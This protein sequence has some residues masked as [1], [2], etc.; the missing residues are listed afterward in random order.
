[1][2]VNKAAADTG[3]PGLL[4]GFRALDLTDAKGYVCGK[5]LANFGVE[6]I[7]VERP[8]GDPGRY[9]YPFIGGEADP[10]KGVYWNS[11]NSDKK[12]ITLD[13]ETEQGRE[14]FKDLVKQVDFVIESFD[15]GY[16][17]GLGLGYAEL[18]KLNPRIVVTSITP[19]GQHTSR[20]NYRGGEMIC[21]A[22]CAIMDNIGD[23]DRAPL[24]E[25]S[26]TCTFF[27]NVA[28][29][30]GTMT[31]HYA[32]QRCGEGQQVDVSIE[33]AIASR[34]PQGQM[35]WMFNKKAP[36]RMGP[37]SKYGIAKVR[38][39]WPCK[40][41]FINWTLFAGN[42]GAKGNSALCKWMNED[43]LEN[44][45]NEIEDWMKFDMSGMTEEDHAHWETCIAAFFLN[46]TKEELS[47]EGAKR[48][49]SATVLADPADVLA[50]EHLNARDYWT[51]LAY[52]EWGMD[53][54]QPKF[55]C[56]TSETDNY[57]HRRAPHIGEHNAEIYGQLGLTDSLDSLRAAGVI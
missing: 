37:Y 12:S 52:P 19:F 57:T 22:L 24:L 8:G 54:P 32:R 50:N 5:I 4:T 9:R 29:V 31:A 56:L 21:A 13:L 51:R 27:A 44:P 6:V 28:A 1:M 43:G 36:K 30:T 49:L 42:L 38:T 10:E 41:G 15:P 34:N 26:D 16:L 33:E 11:Y 25:P 23:E 40:D 35:G 18:S 7:K 53:L 39:V 2:D 45:L 20:R 47:V 3:R 48:R 17:D 46:H 55:F 14:I